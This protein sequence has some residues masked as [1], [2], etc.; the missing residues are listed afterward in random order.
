MWSPQ[1]VW[2]MGTAYDMFISLIVLH[3]PVDFGI[4]GAWAAGMRSRLPSPEREILEQAQRV[5]L[6]KSQLAWVYTLP[7]PKD[8]VT[9]LEAL[10]RTAPAERL[11]A[12]ASYSWD[13]TSWGVV[14]QEVAT[15]QAWD[16][17]DREALLAAWH[18]G[19]QSGS[20]SAPDAEII[21]S[22]WA[23]S[24]EF[25]ERYLRALR[26]YYECF[27]AEEEVRILPALKEGL[28]RAQSL[29]EELPFPALIEELSQGVHY[30]VLELP[31]LPELALV[32][33][34]WGDPL[35]WADLVGDDRVL[36]IF[37]ARP[38][39]ASLVPGEVVPDV[40]LQAL[41]A[42]ADPTRLRIVRYLASESLTP[43]QLSHRL[44]LRVPTVVHHL[45]TLRIARLVEIKRAGKEVSYTVRA[46]SIIAT[47][48]SLR[49]FVGSDSEER[50]SESN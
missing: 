35:V 38:T 41:K 27:F 23:R 42:L 1:L 24:E 40:L 22:W 16:E 21:L 39:D 19:R 43:T 50:P 45:N 29:A 6:R 48:D 25:G 10:E 20:L 8:S 33:S 15:R 47:C 49:G 7:A 30:D 3:T 34:Y 17:R 14:L 28:R 13:S 46:Q 26:A 5:F 11:P 37:G 4:R 44:R 31:E 2:D 32:P 18:E 36:L 9:A 12:L